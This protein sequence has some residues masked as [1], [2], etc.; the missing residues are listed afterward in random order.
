M[1]GMEVRGRAERDRGTIREAPRDCRVALAFGVLRAHR[2]GG[3][4]PS[5]RYAVRES[6][7]PAGPRQLLLWSR[8]ILVVVNQPP[9][10]HLRV[11]CNQGCGGATAPGPEPL[12]SYRFAM[13][14]ERPHVGSKAVVVM[15]V[16]RQGVLLTVAVCRNVAQAVGDAISRS[17]AGTIPACRMRVRAVAHELSD[18]CSSDSAQCVEALRRRGRSARDARGRC[19]IAEC[20]AVETGHRGAAAELASRTAPP[21][22]RPPARDGA[23]HCPPRNSVKR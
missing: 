14:G 11:R 13:R 23:T 9:S 21:A 1:L 20:G 15:Q 7:R 8:E 12:Q 2:P 3:A 16:I 4:T 17:E 10:S 5:P 22:P 18:R 6:R 19:R